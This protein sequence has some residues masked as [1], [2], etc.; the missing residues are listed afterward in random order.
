M[1]KIQV[2]RVKHGVSTISGK[3]RREEYE[4]EECVAAVDDRRITLTAGRPWINQD[5]DE[6]ALC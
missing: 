4:C 5:A 6:G 3:R 1:E 2:Q